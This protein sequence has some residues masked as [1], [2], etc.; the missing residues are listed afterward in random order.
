MGFFGI[1]KKI[2]S[3]LET[4]IGLCISCLLIIVINLSLY[5]I[6]NSQKF[7]AKQARKD[8]SAFSHFFAKKFI[9]FYYYTGNF[10]LGTSYKDLVYSKEGAQKEIDERG[11]DLIME[12]YHWSRL[13]ENTRILAYLP[14]A[15]LDGGVQ[16][17][18]IRFFNTLIFIAGLIAL[19]LGFWYI[20]KPLLG[21]VLITL[22]NTTPFYLF[23]IFSRENIFGVF[24]SIFY[25]I[26]GLNL[27]FLFKKK[28]NDFSKF[29]IPILSAMIIGFF[30]EIRNEIS[31]VLLSL[32]M[33][34]VFSQGIS[35]KVKAIMILVAIFAFSKTREGLRIFFKE[36]FAKTTQLVA[37]NGGHVYTGGH[38]DG[39]ML[40]HPIFCGLGDFDTKYGYKWDDRVAFNYAMPILN[41][42]YKL[43]LKYNGASYHLNMYYDKA[44][45]YY[46][47]F[48]EIP[49]YE[50]IVKEKVLTDIKN[51]PLWYATIIW[52]RIIR[53]MSR[54]LPIKYLGFILFPLLYY[55]IEQKKWHWLKLLMVSFP[56]SATSIIIYSDRGTTYNSVFG[57][58]VVIITVYEIY[59]YMERIMKQEELTPTPSD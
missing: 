45:K 58:F 24:P 14:N 19:F 15:W 20:K 23:E 55:I 54:T 18:S 4:K 59:K 37:E 12:Y 48:D 1:L 13:G 49:E 2:K 53:V 25:L 17:P 56:L 43:N 44:K 42:D 32:I 36:K 34:Y 30:S 41:D 57:Y 3:F 31:I 51:D 52:K 50:P 27:H 22:I 38:I 26:L 28:E 16:K 46:I 40:W 39:H 8:A 9:Y 35:Y 5:S 6:S 29:Y 47:K 10:P 7:S 21:L 33:I 11:E